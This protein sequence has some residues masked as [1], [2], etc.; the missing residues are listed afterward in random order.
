MP[1]SNNALMKVYNR[2][3]ITF[4]H[5][6][7]VY[8][9]DDTGK[10]YFDAGSGIAVNA[11]GHCH[12]DIVESLYTQSKKLWHISNL[13]YSQPQLDLASLLCEKSFAD[14]VFFTNSGAEAVEC[15]LKT[16]WRY[17]HALGQT[18]RRKIITFKGAFHGRT[19]LCISATGTKT[20]D[21]YGSVTD[22]FVI[23]PFGDHYAL[24]QAMKNPDTAA[25]MIEPIQGEGGVR[26]VP[27]HCLQ[28]LRKMCDEYGV[29]LICDEIQSGMG[30]TGTL[31]AFEHAGIVPDICTS[32]KG[33]AGG[34]P[35]G[36]C[37]VSER[38]SLGMNVGTHG[39]TYGG[40]PL[41]CAVGLTALKMITDPDFLNNVCIT[42]NDL[43]SKLQDLKQAYPHI[44]KDIRGAGFMLGIGLHDNFNARQM[45]EIL[46]DAGL[47][48]IPASDNVLRLLPPLIITPQH[49]IEIIHLLD[50]SF[51]AIK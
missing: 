32:A 9:F 8:V 15:A 3:P 14:Y 5:G 41:G 30:R 23:L 44:I 24:E 31:F 49:N 19:H 17:F 1:H 16:A 39:S 27:H 11:F 36:A 42:G 18:N 28:A 51:K 22:D 37:L 20:D 50:T 25:V 21:G 4:T 47:I 48:V 12:P 43:K 40:N 46:L 34:F 45:A 10:R 38:A 6:Q 26:S 35:L 29:L 7:G 33:V 2:F 13:Y